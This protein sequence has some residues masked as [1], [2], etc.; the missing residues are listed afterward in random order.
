M[1]PMAQLADVLGNQLNAPVIDK[2]GLT[3][4]Y[5][6][7]LDFAPEPGQGPAGMPLLPPPPPGGGDAGA[8]KAGLAGDSSDAPSLF[9]AVQEQ[10]GLKL[11]K[12]KGPLEV[13]V[14]DHAEKAPTEN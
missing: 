5:D 7:T 12:R 3:G 2:T 6:F 4:K 8:V 13:I 1:Q 14:V 9:N 11:E 10:L